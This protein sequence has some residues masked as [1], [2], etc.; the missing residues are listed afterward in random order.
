[1]THDVLIQL[2]KDSLDDMVEDS[3]ESACS[4][5]MCDARCICRMYRIIHIEADFGGY[6]PFGV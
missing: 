5:G 1:M 3:V 4:T 6:D 2:I